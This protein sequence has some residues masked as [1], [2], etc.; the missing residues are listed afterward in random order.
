MSKSSA[1]SVITGCGS[2]LFLTL[3]SQ[4]IIGALSF[5]YSST[6]SESPAGA[7]CAVVEAFA[8]ATPAGVATRYS[9][10]NPASCPSIAS[11]VFLSL[12]IA[13]LSSTMSFSL[14]GAILMSAI[15]PPALRSSSI[16]FTSSNSS[17]WYGRTII[18]LPSVSSTFGIST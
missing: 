17:K 16:P 13:L 9:S 7:L 15:V 1:L 14:S 6:F 18:F 8:M 5:Q 4:R 10:P 12:E 11:A 3:F 2:G